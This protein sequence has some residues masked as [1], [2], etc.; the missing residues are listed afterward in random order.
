MDETVARWLVTAAGA[1]ALAGLLF[2]IAFARRGAGVVEPVAQDGTW[3]F[4]LLIIPGAATLWPYL[5]LRW[6]R[7]RR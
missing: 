4:R 1:Y 3:G 6:W 7:A 2:A 5:L